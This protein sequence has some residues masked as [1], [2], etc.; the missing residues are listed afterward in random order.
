MLDERLGRP[1]SRTTAARHSTRTRCMRS[2]HTTGTG[3]NGQSCRAGHSTSYSRPSPPKS[4]L[5]HAVAAVVDANCLPI[6]AYNRQGVPLDEA[7]NNFRKEITDEVE[8]ALA[9]FCAARNACVAAVR[10]PTEVLTLTFSYCRNYFDLTAAARVCR[11]WRGTILSARKLWEYVS[12]RFSLSRGNWGSA[13]KTALDRAGAALWFMK[14]FF[15]ASTLENELLVSLMKPTFENLAHLWVY[16]QFPEGDFVFGAIIKLPAPRL[17]TVLFGSEGTTMLRLP[18]DLFA[19]HAPKLRCIWLVNTLLPEALPADA[20]TFNA[21]TEVA[22]HDLQVMGTAEIARTCRLCPK[23]ENFT[24]LANSW[25][26]E[27]EETPTDFVSPTL[28]NI[29]I[30]NFLA[31]GI[32]SQI[33]D[34]NMSMRSQAHAHGGCHLHLLDQNSLYATLPLTIIRNPR[35]VQLTFE[36]SMEHHITDMSVTLFASHHDTD[37]ETSHA[38]GVEYLPIHSA[39]D[40]L[41]LGACTGLLKSVQKLAIADSL[42]AVALATRC[43]PPDSMPQLEHLTI[44]ITPWATV[45]LPSLFALFGD[46]MN[47]SDTLSEVRITAREAKDGFHVTQ[48]VELDARAVDTFLPLSVHTLTLFSVRLIHLMDVPRFEPSGRAREDGRRWTWVGHENDEIDDDKANVLVLPYIP[49]FEEKKGMDPSQMLLPPSRSSSCT[50]EVMGIDRQESNQSRPG[51]VRSASLPNAHTSLSLNPEARLRRVRSLSQSDACSL[52]WDYPW[53]VH[54]SPDYCECGEEECIARLR[55]YSRIAGSRSKVS[56]RQHSRRPSGSDVRRGRSP[57][58][59]H[60]NVERERQ[61]SEEVRPACFP[62]GMHRDSQNPRS[63]S[64]SPSQ[65]PIES[66]VEVECTLAPPTAPDPSV[67]VSSTAALKPRPF[68]RP[69]A[70]DCVID[71]NLPAVRVVYETAIPPGDRDPFFKYDVRWWLTNDTFNGLVV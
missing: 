19:G 36:P 45:P 42:L 44:H 21:V 20:T 26:V 57:G 1:L 63:Q 39:I 60:S 56:S 8:A 29:C 13:L 3:P 65:S 40:A 52:A 69:P 12:I 49:H 43:L 7:V 15:I 22:Y 18:D 35:R 9:E 6:M 70:P 41:A 71:L 50:S 66:Q 31:H 11:Y 61:R 23:L 34:F 54:R 14:L 5:R 28:K 30:R 25:I 10:V 47:A 68:S 64:C 16:E 46:R 58:T 55:A 2:R 48:A 32:I 59:Q 38:A 67:L 62:S 37:T 24:I 27:G 33:I 4:T 51:R 53:A 17:E